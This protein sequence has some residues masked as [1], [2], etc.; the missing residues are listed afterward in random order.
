MCQVWHKS[1]C[2]L[3]LRWSTLI[4]MDG[5]RSGPRIPSVLAGEKRLTLM[6]TDPQYCV[7]IAIWPGGSPT[8][9]QEGVR[10]ALLA[11]FLS[12]QQ[13]HQKI[14]IRA[15]IQYP[16]Y[17]LQAIRADLKILCLN[18]F[19]SYSLLL[20][21]F[22]IHLFSHSN[23]TNHFTSISWDKLTRKKYPI[24]IPILNQTTRWSERAEEAWPWS[25]CLRLLFTCDF[26]C[27]CR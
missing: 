8:K 6:A 3:H 14:F 12:A 25:C 11:Y 19:S 26:V 1:A 7:W 27:L 21:V 4:D 22:Q 15:H 20:T 5:H 23:K 9:R 24:S 10:K 17:R 16:C 2:K 13:S 18:A